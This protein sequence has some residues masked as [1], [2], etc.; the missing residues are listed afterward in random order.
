MGYVAVLLLAFAGGAVGAGKYVITRS[1]QIKP[2]SVAYANLSPAVQRALRSRT[3]TVRGEA[4][5]A[6]PAGA[7][8][9]PG[10]VGAKGDRGPAGLAGA[11]GSQGAAGGTGPQGPAGAQGPQGVQGPTGPQGADGANDLAQAS[12]LVA[13]TA[14]PAMILQGAA[15]TNGSI[16]GASV[17]LEAGDVIHSLAELVTS[18]GS[19]MTHG[20]YAIYDGDLNLVAQTADTPAAF[21]VTN[22][23]AELSL[24]SSYTVAASGRYYFVDLL[25]SSTTMPSI[26]NIGSLAAS[27]S[28]NLLP[29]GIA[30]GVNGGSGLSDFPSTLTPTT[31]GVSRC[32]VAE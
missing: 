31:T 12:G 29:S 26:G 6:G 22:Q 18:A 7:K 27:S 8:G 13:W 32:M 23:W 16:H 30:R 17:W 19:G 10:A 24:T 15:D 11:T 1:S 20:M 4:G 28:R 21:Q 5:S 2:G 9:D 14:D 3:T 25:A